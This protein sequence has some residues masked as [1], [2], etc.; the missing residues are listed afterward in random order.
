MGLTRSTLALI[1]LISLWWREAKG[2][3]VEGRKATLVRASRPGFGRAS[4]GTKRRT[5]GG[6]LVVG[7]RGQGLRVTP[8]LMSFI[9][10][11]RPGCGL[12][13]EEGEGREV[14]VRWL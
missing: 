11:R 14:R 1:S 12:G 5:E 8:F 9:R 13:R 4:W 2:R 7:G 3:E 6:W 10:A